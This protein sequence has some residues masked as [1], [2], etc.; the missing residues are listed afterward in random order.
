M[1]VYR[2]NSSLQK[3]IRTP[4]FTVA[5]FTVSQRAGA[6]QASAADE[7]INKMGSIRG[8]EHYSAFERK[9]ALTQATTWRNLEDIRLNEISQSQK[10]TTYCTI[11]LRGGIERSQILETEGQRMIVRGWEGGGNGELVS[12]G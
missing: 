6:T 2:A 3:V 7:E 8:T 9:G 5:L 1:W 11:P 12:P 4:A 10:A